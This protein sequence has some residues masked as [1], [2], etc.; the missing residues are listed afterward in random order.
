MIALVDGMNAMHNS[1]GGLMVAAALSNPTDP[2]S[3]SMVLI[4]GFLLYIRYMKINYTPEVL[5]MLKNIKPL[6]IPLD[7]GI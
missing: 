4:S 6:R 7:F 1:L 3:I 2:S 5:Y